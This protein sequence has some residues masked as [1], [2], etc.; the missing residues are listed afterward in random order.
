MTKA[1][2]HDTCASYQWTAPTR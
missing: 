1:L 2:L